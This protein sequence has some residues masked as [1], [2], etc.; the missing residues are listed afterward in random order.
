MSQETVQEVIIKAVSEPEFREL[1]F[2]DLD[3]AL[4]GFDLTEEEIESLKQM[5]T[6]MLDEYFGELEERVSRTG[7]PMKTGLQQQP[8]LSAKQAGSF[9]SA[10]S[11]SQKISN[12]IS[13]LLNSGSN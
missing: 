3:K 13:N 1:L 5:D 8:R 6:G 9:S 12:A 11:F 2:S 4:E 10:L 7:V